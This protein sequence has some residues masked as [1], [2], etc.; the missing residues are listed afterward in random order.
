[1]RAPP[2]PQTPIQADDHLSL[3][4]LSRPPSACSYISLASS[5][6]SFRSVFSFDVDFSALETSEPPGRSAHVVSPTPQSAASHVALVEDSIPGSP[7]QNQDSLN[8]DDGPPLIILPPCTP[9]E[10]SRHFG[11]V[12]D[13]ASPLKHTHSTRV[14]RQPALDDCPALSR[15]P[16]PTI[17]VSSPRSTTGLPTQ[18]TPLSYIDTSALSPRRPSPLLLSLLP[19]PHADL[20]PSPSADMIGLGL[21]IEGATL[22]H[23]TTPQASAR[24]LPYR[25]VGSIGDQSPIRD[26]RSPRST[27]NSQAETL[28]SCFRAVARDRTLSERSRSTNSA[29]P[30]GDVPL[31]PSPASTHG[32]TT[33]PGPCAQLQVQPSHR[34]SPNH[35]FYPP[36]SAGDDSDSDH[37]PRA[38]PLLSPSGLHITFGLPTPG[39]SPVQVPVVMRSPS[40]DPRSP[41]RQGMRIPGDIMMGLSQLRVLFPFLHCF[42]WHLGRR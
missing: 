22:P 39:L 36:F 11:N 29:A 7:A 40:A 1:L 18:S 12:S 10:N 34:P 15:L 6:D 23:R 17:V 13:A 21:S 35:P 9:S 25:P 30:S 5:S 31:P 4:V 19:Q 16:S 41:I 2:R 42:M 32:G 37:W 14:D 28:P 27:P 33:S 20:G 24:I 8:E 26:N 3:P 38:P